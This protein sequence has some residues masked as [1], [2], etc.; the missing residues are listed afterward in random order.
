MLRAVL[1]NCVSCPP[2]RDADVLCCGGAGTEQGK[3]AAAAV[4]RYCANSEHNR[5]NIMRGKAAEVLVDLLQTSSP[6]VQPMR[7]S[8]WNKPS[9]TAVI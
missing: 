2:P 7:C 8:C 5:A 6:K 3:E 4:I 1:N 9:A